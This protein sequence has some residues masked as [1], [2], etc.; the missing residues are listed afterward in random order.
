MQWE[1]LALVKEKD[2]ITFEDTYK[3]RLPFRE[4]RFRIRRDFKDRHNARITIYQVI[5]EE[6]YS[7]STIEK[8]NGDYVE[9]IFKSPCN[10]ISFGE[11]IIQNVSTS[12][13][14]WQL[15]REIGLEYRTFR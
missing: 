14:L 10:I 8:Y 3:Q 1:S 7:L 4:I 5:D 9:Y 13:N 11:A 12:S 6:G 2:Y 15:T